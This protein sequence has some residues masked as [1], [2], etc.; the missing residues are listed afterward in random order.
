MPKGLVPVQGVPLAGRTIRAFVR[1]GIS[2][3][4][5]IVNEESPELE[6]YLRRTDFGVSVDILV[7]STPSSMHSLFALAPFLDSSPFFLAT[8]DAVYDPA[9]LQSW[10]ERCAADPDADGVLAVT[11]FVDDEKPL[12][13][14][15]GENDRIVNIGDAAAG[16]SWITGGLYRFSPRIFNEMERAGRLGLERLR[17]FQELLVNE[18]YSLY[19]HRFGTIVDVDHRADIATAEAYLNQWSGAV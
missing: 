10:I 13:V 12:Y 5:G 9:D 8:V 19:G 7:R 6:E 11:R 17:K 3:V 16:S 15:L 4:A 1:N 14:E 18:G 2:R